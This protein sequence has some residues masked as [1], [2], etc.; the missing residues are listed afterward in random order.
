MTGQRITKRVVDSLK[1][2]PSEYAVWDVKMPGFGVRVRP[3]GA[4]SYV[5]VYRAGSGRGAP[6][7]RYTIGTVGKITP[8]KARL[9]AKGILGAVAHGKDP[10]ADKATERSTPTVAELADRFMAEHIEPKRKP[11]T[12]VFYRDILNRIVK[13]ELGTAKADKVTR[14]AVA[15]VHGKLRATP[16]QANRML[17]VVGSMYAFAARIG[18]VPEG[19]N[20]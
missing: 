20:P 5:V 18:A 12:T 8:E 13:P 17:A 16:F 4:M 3:T 6:Y 1:I 10:A 19:I 2:R 11:G 15:K 7:R 9:R 14:A